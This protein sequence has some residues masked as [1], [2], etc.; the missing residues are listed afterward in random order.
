MEEDV[1]KTKLVLGILPPEFI[2]SI[3]EI[4]AFIIRNSSN[5]LLTKSTGE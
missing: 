5:A 3:P 4:K 1:W 2:V